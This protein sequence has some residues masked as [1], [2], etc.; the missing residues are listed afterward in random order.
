MKAIL[1]RARA[2]RLGSQLWPWPDRPRVVI[3]DADKVRGLE[4]ATAF[5]RAGYAV[6]VCPGPA[7][8]ASCPL[9]Q[10]EECLLVDGADVVVWRLGA[11]AG[12]GVLEGLLRRRGGRGVVVEL[13]PEEAERR[14]GELEGCELVAAPASPERL[15][16][17]VWSR[18]HAAAAVPGDRR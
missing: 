14:R 18:E 3:E 6:A 15:V 13:E 1:P 12:R 10:L 5:R 16:E 17:A 11:P 8:Q 4:T 2:E 9:E 7:G